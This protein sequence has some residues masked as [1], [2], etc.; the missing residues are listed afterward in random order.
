MTNFQPKIYSGEIVAG[1]L[2]VEESRKI[3]RLL[4]DDVD[5]QEW[6]QAIVI[7]NILQK[8]SPEAARRQAR[9]IKARLSLMTKDLWKMI[10]EGSS[11]TASQALLSASIKHS[12]LVGDFMDTILRQHWLTFTKQITTADWKDYLDECAQIEPHVESW[13]PSTRSKLKQ[14]VFRMLSEA[15]YIDNT[16]TCKL[17]PVSLSPQIRGYLVKNDESY[18]LRCMEI[19]L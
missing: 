19:S 10:V 14:I 7:D 18:V 3:A 11:E 6:R 9:L 12:R 17:T 13:K 15:G 2:L 5:T 1:A 8:R 16:K 4:I